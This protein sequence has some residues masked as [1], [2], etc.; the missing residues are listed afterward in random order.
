MTDYVYTCCL[1]NE[2]ES[3]N[4]SLAMPRSDCSEETLLLKI[5]QM[6]ESDV[7]L[8]KDHPRDSTK[9]ERLMSRLGINDF[10]I[11]EIASVG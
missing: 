7:T 2:Q 9:K 1:T 8:L 10:K 6:K 4:E 11:V 5:A 3:W